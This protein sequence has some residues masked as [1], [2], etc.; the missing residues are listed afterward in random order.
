[1]AKRTGGTGGVSN[2]C[3]DWR[4]SNH[5]HPN[6]VHHEC[7]PVR[8]P[9]EPAG[10]LLTPLNCAYARSPVAAL[11]TSGADVDT[12]ALNVR[13]VYARRRSEHHHA[14]PAGKN[15]WKLHLMRSPH[16]AS[17]RPAFG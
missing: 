12:D 13:A 11:R 17:D 3:A 14:A 4:H 10:M 15:W 16:G 6:R 9:A 2:D 7:V 1:S 8:A 5:R